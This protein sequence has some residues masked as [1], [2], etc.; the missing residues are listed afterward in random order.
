M[1]TLIRPEISRKKDEWIS[2]H[3]YYELK[4][5]S[6]QYP[7]WK[8]KLADRTYILGS[9]VAGTAKKSQIEFHDPTF[10]NVSVS[11]TYQRNIEIVEKACEMASHE[12]KLYLLLVLTE[13]VTYEYLKMVKGMPCG[14]SSFYKMYRK[15]FWNLDRLKT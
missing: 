13:G 15:A 2:K 3:R 7:E 1:S 5:F 9:S 14:R 10:E 12:F 6:L 8:R 11:E 4:H